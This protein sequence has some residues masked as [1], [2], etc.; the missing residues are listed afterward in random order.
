MEQTASEMEERLAISEK[1]VFRSARAVMVHF[2]V[3]AMAHARQRLEILR[4]AEDDMGV[5]TWARI[6]AAIEVLHAQD[7]TTDLY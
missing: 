3:E 5:S 2:G 1:E 4:A 6:I 7:P